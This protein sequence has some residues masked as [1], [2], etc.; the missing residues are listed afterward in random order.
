MELDPSIYIV[1]HS[2]LSLKQGVTT[3]MP[4]HDLIKIEKLFR[5]Q[6]VFMGLMYMY[7]T[8]R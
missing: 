8:P 1:M 6:R 7:N 5:T 3:I 2:V 4:S